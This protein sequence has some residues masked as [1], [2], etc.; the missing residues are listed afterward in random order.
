MVNIW[1]IITQLIGGRCPLC[2]APGSGLCAPCRDDLPYNAHA[3]PRCALPLAARGD[4]PLLCADC[5]ARPP[6]FD[7]ARA[8]LIYDYPID[9][10]I[11]GLKYHHRLALG[12][13][14]A[15]VLATAIDPNGALPR[16]LLPV[17]MHR[18]RLRERG[19]NQAAELAQHLSA[20]LNIPWS[21][22]YLRRSD[23]GAHQ[24]GLD[25]GKRLRN[26]RGK[27]RCTGRLPA[28]VALIDDVITTGATVDELSRVMRQAGAQTIEVW[29]VA[30][31]PR[32]RRGA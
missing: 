3:C 2:G 23:D 17:P 32:E 12:R 20:R 14:L 1:P 15:D 16:L 19:F 28:S 30:R 9:D 21:T 22:A 25:R 8:P 31:T 4:R 6:A 10:L 7:R 18:R 29:A 24:R 13:D 11:A 27:F 5:Q 26:I